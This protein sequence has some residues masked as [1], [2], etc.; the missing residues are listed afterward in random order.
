MKSLY[1]TSIESYSGKTAFCLAIGR[2]LRSRRQLV[3][4]LKPLSTQPR[5]VNGRVIDE[6]VEFV[7][8]ALELEESPHTLAPVVITLDLLEQKLAG[9]LHRNLAGEV[10]QAFRQVSSGKDVMLLEGGASLREGYV[11]GLSTVSMAALLGAQTLVVIRWAGEMSAL[12]DALTARFRLGDNLL[13]VVY[14]AVPVDH[15]DW[16]QRVARPA[17]ENYAVPVFGLLPR[18]S[19]L[20]AVSVAELADVLRARYLTLPDQR[21]ALCES[22][23]VGAMTVDAALARFRRQRNKAVITGGDRTD[24]QLAALETSTRCL[25]L[26]GEI[27]PEPH[28]LARAGELGVPVLLTAHNTVEALEA[29]ERVFGKTRLG[30]PE[31]LARF[32]ALMD[33]HFDY[34]RLFEAL[35][36]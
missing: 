35:A 11:A 32:E 19:R 13:G 36:L 7:A 34:P 8:R 24:I 9:A 3:G 29:I 23:S 14:N 22:L 20:M 26:T 21:F 28:V 6:D 5:V 31:K 4:Y 12:D 10:E 15:L 27:Q 16:L 17:L 1:I 33:E 2:K 30:Q 18:E 25:V